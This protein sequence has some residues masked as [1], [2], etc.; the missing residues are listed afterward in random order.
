MC[1]E[2]GDIDH[3]GAIAKKLPR[4]RG[5]RVSRCPDVVYK[6]GCV[7]YGTC[8]TY[9][10]VKAAPSCVTWEPREALARSETERSGPAGAH[11]V[12]E[13]VG[14]QRREVKPS[15]ELSPPCGGRG[16]QRHRR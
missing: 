7:G 1:T 11:H 15:C 13:V 16:D 14:L 3:R 2:R 9:T 8:A 5:G 4:T 10:S 12:R 6:K